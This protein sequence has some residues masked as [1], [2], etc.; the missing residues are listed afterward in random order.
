MS[1]DL[2]APHYRWMEWLSAGGKL[3]RCRTAFLDSITPPGKVLIYGEG[4]GRF[5]VELCRRFPQAEVTVV[6][7]SAVML[8]HARKRLEK[9][10]GGTAKVHFIHA[11]ALIWQPPAGQF[12]LLVTCFFLDCFRGDELR[13]LV[14][15][16]AAAASA[17]AQWLLADFQVAGGGLARLRSRVILT[18]LYAFFRRATG[19]SAHEVVDPAPLLQAGGFRCEHQV[20]HDHGLLYS[21]LWVR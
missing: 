20:E 7:A 18:V 16:I 17:R 15:V 13:R 4:N 8:T 14:P 21:S 3:Q 9:S 12:D 10:L 2:L 11:D 19:L 5:L 6:D 1:F